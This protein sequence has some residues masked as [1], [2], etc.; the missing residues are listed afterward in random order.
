MVF[1]L[2]EQNEIPPEPY[3]CF[4]GDFQRQMPL[5][6]T[7]KDKEGKIIDVPRTQA[8]IAD[9]I[10][11]RMGA[12]TVAVDNWRGYRFFTGDGAVSNQDGDYL[13]VLENLLPPEL[14]FL[15]NCY[16]ECAPVSEMYGGAVV[17]PDGAWDELK[18]QKDKV[19]HLT[20]EE[21]QEAYGK[22]YVQKDGAWV[23][24]NK[25]VGKAWDALS[26]GKDLTS[27]LRL[28]GE[29]CT[30]SD[31]SYSSDRIL[32]VVFPFHAKYLQSMVPDFQS[33]DQDQNQKLKIAQLA[34]GMNSSIKAIAPLTNEGKP[35]MR[36]WVIEGIYT[37]SSVNCWSY[38][39]GSGFTVGLIPK[40]REKAL[41]ARVLS[42]L[43]QGSEFEFKGRVYRPVDSLERK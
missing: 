3:K 18:G 26:R 34:T 30:G 12:L 17:L 35:L 40:A 5:L 1:Q 42:A 9:V 11:R 15:R 38:T 28:V 21:V 6:L 33:M 37:I 22:G 43:E 32:P 23:P 4:Y 41:E 39:F 10:E 36:H 14:Q 31:K 13:I 19:M 27:Y 25:A 8:S 16:L 24:A 20:A 7:G 2:S 29:I